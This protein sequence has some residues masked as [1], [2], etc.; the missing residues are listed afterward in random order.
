MAAAVASSVS[1]SE[2]GVAADVELELS[3]PT[4]DEAIVVSCQPGER[5]G[6]SRDR[7]LSLT[8]DYPLVRLNLFL[9]EFVIVL[10]KERGIHPF[11]KP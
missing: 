3:P 5:G 1:S 10:L 11:S 4:L 2:T 9:L 8:H 7:D 6:G